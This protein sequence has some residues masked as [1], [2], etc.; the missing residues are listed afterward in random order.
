MDSEISKAVDILKSGGVVGIPT[1]T[2]YGLAGSIESKDGLEN[3]F[4]TKERPFFDPLIVHVSSAAQAESYTSEWNEICECLTQSFWPGPLTI[5][6]KKN[7][8]VEDVIT[9][10]LDSVGLRMPNHPMAL[11]L[12][13][14]LGHPVA[15]PSANKFKKTSPTKPEHVQESFPEVLTLDGGACEVGIESTVVGIKNGKV[16]IYRPGMITKSQMEEA[17][18]KFEVAATVEYGESPVAPGQMKHHY[19]PKVPVILFNNEKINE[20]KIPKELRPNPKE[21]KLGDNP[22]VAARRLYGKLREYDKEYSCILIYLP[23]KKG[24]TES[25]LGIKNRL[26]KAASITI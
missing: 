15:A 11:N 23:P 8:K 14:E 20:A 25:W 2:V 10:G 5:V 24:Q 12:I 16:T 18:H 17:L 4:K 22:A 3:I 19:M 7:S 9:A 1:E 13:E 21:L 6:V 26:M